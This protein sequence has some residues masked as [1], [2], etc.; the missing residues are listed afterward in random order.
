MYNYKS[1][2]DLAKK[3]IK[4]ADSILLTCHVHPDGDALGSVLA[5]MHALLKINKNVT[6]TFPSPFEIPATL[7]DTL[8]GLDL[9]CPPESI[10]ENNFDLVMTFDCGSITRIEG[11]SDVFKNSKKLINV[12]HHV[13]NEKFGD[14]NIIDTKAASSGSVVLEIID[15]LG[16]ELD[17]NIA[18]CIYVAL[19]TDTGRFQFSSTNKDVFDQ[20]SRLSEYDLPIAFLSRKL[21]EE[22]SF[23]FM[24]LCG[25]VLAQMKI[26]NELSFVYAVA[27]TEMREKYKLSYSDLEG[28]I[29]FVRRTK[30]ADVACVLKEFEPGVYKGSMRSL[31][32][33]DV[34][35]IA[36]EFN[37]GGH[38]FAAGFTSELI[39]DEIIEQI[40]LEISK[41]KEK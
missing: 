25:D 29:E 18:Q 24:K 39:P 31:G 1:E 35:V 30:E 9:L 8:P 2:I 37:G 13:S 26:D 3:E 33:I 21:T 10:L 15:E 16:V 27:T 7:R 20:A 34:C 22:D 14:I 36:S 19:L 12:D 41:Q 32:E 6:A 23:Q 4:L 28:L 17:K 11:L 5:M 38:K 40:K